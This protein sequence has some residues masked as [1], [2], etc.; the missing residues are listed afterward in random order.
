MELKKKVIYDGF[1]SKWSIVISRW[2]KKE[3]KN[4]LFPSKTWHE[5]RDFSVFRMT[6]HVKSI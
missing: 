3:K 1:L 4:F 5:S 2:I 6:G